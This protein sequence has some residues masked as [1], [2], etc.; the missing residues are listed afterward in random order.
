MEFREVGRAAVRNHD[1]AIAAVVGLA[2]RGV[3]ADFRGD[4]AHQE[5]LDAVLLQ[6]IVELGGVECA[7]ARLVDHDLA[8]ARIQRGND[9][10]AGLA[11][12]Q[13]AAHRAGIADA[14]G[15]RTA[16]DLRRRRVGEVRQMS[17]AGMDDEDAVIS[18]RRQ[19]GGDRLH[20]AGQLRD[21]IAEGLAKTARL[22]EVALHVDD[23]KRRLRPVEFDR[24]RL[25]DDM[26]DE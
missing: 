7:L 8:G 21:V 15:W 16:R 14:Q 24:L 25:G 3:D 23:D 9:V 2:H 18:R 17:L 19:H 20:R 10:V 26:A 1:A 22:H 5:V 11:A 12:D 13:D 4:A 6:D